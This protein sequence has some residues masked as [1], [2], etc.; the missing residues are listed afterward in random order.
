MIVDYKN[1]QISIEGTPILKNVDLSI[2]EGDFVF[3]TGKVGS[4]KTSLLRT[5]YG[6]LPVEGE[7]AMI[8][9]FNMLSLKR[10]KLPDLRKSLGII[11]QNF[12]LLPDRTVFANLEFVLKATGWKKRG[13]IDNRIKKVL[14]QVGLSD[15]FEHYPHELS[16]GEQQRIAIARAILNRP[17]L[18]IAD[19]PTGNLDIDNSKLIVNILSELSQNGTAVIMTTHNLQLIPMVKSRIFNCEDHSLEEITSIYH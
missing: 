1:V 14:Q 16:G 10:K 2:N 19:E 13:D 9:D 6:V 15:K 8:L 4:G 5:M 11:F 12:Q 7:R 18:I 17:Q 3:L